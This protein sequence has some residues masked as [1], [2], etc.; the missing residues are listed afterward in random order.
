MIKVVIADGCSL[1]A[2]AELQD[3]HLND[4]GQ[5]SSK[6]SWASL[7]HKTL[8]PNAEF[9][10][11]S[12]SG[13]SNS[14][15]RRRVIYNVNQALKNYSPDEILVLVMWTGLGRKEWRLEKIINTDYGY[16]YGPTEANYFY[17]LGH[18]AIIKDNFTKKVDRFLKANNLHDIVY[19]FNRFM[20]NDY[21]RLYDWTNEIY[22]TINFCKSKKVSIKQTYGFSDHFNYYNNFEPINLKDQFIENLIEELNFFE[23]GF[24]YRQEHKKLGFNEF[25]RD[26]NFPIGEGGHPLEEAHKFWAK[27]FVRWYRKNH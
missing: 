23:D 9:I 12:R 5:E 19:N 25:S 20:Q 27:E 18:W 26:F 7:V 6:N 24:F 13:S 2:G 16:L 8:F 11:C 1:T 17:S 21:V 4:I 14:H 22:S 10:C 3:W 15:I